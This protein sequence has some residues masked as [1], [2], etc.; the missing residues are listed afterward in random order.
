[1]N[2]VWGYWSTDG[3]GFYEYLQLCELLGTEPV[4]VINNGV[5]HDE[6]VQ[7][8]NIQP[9]I[10]DTGQSRVCDG[11]HVDQVGEASR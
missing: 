8:S 7:T 1:M 11:R 10:Q 6:S 3:L 4:W 9:R 2:D 5:S